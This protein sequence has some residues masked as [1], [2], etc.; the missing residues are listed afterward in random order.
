M[1]IKLL[2][3]LIIIAALVWAVLKCSH[4]VYPVITFEPGKKVFVFMDNKFNRTATISKNMA[5]GVIIYDQFMLPINYRGKFYA[6]G[7]LDGGHKLIYTTKRSHIILAVYAEF[8]RKLIGCQD[9]EDPTVEQ[10]LADAMD[11][12]MEDTDDGS[13]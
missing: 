3:I 2:I 12:D 8:A 7:Y 11:K 4:L 9:Y 1:T 6:I 13:N 5:A 10:T